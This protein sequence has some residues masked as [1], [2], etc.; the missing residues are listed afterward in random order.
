MASNSNAAPSHKYDPNFTQNVID[1][2]GPKT[3]PRAREIMSSLI[4]H[5]HD[6]ARETE[7]TIEEWTIGT[8]FLNSIGQIS[9]STRNEGHRMSD[10]IGLET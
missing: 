4:R 8:Q 1:L 10:I 7:L 6:F 9:T 2:I 3:P 5:I